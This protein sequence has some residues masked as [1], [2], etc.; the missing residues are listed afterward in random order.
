MKN[1]EKLKWILFFV[2]APLNDYETVASAIRNSINCT[3]LRPMQCAP[4][5]CLAERKQRR[6]LDWDARQF[7]RNV[8]AA[9]AA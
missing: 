3:A 5:L 7:R 2:T 8:N 6:P 1:A 9:H 4:A